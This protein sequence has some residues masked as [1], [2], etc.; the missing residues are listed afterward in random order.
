M[1]KIGTI[2]WVGLE[3]GVQNPDL[4]AVGFCSALLSRATGPY[5]AR[6]KTTCARLTTQWRQWVYWRERR[7]CGWEGRE[8]DP[9]E[10]R[11]IH[12]LGDRRARPSASARFSLRRCQVLHFVIVF[13]LRAITHSVAPVIIAPRMKLITGSLQSDKVGKNRGKRLNLEKHFH[14]CRRQ[15]WKCAHDLW[16]LTSEWKSVTYSDWRNRVGGS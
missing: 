10:R 16:L 4:Y 3:I 5:P 11:H 2:V 14:F 9:H 15:K 12:R 7:Y 1:Q 6:H 13:L 8:G